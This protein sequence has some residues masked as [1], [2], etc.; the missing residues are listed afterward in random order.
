MATSVGMRARGVLGQSTGP[1]P[2]RFKGKD[3]I[4]IGLMGNQIQSQFFGAF[5]GSV[6]TLHTDNE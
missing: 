3:R 6:S 5:W 1:S 2:G 4:A